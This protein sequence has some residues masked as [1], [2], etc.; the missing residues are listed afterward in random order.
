MPQPPPTAFP[1]LAPVPVSTPPSDLQVVVLTHELTRGGRAKSSVDLSCALA[2]RGYRVTCLAHPR[3]GVPPH[4]AA[5]LSEAGVELRL[6]RP[7][8]VTSPLTLLRILAALSRLS[9]DVLV[10]HSGPLVAL[11]A[12]LRRHYGNPH[13]ILAKR[14]FWTP[15]GLWRP[16]LRRAAGHVDAVACVS[17]AVARFWRLAEP[18]WDPSSIFVIHNGVAVPAESSAS[19]DALRQELGLPATA[20]VVG[21]VARMEWEK[22]HQHLIESLPRVLER[23]P[24]AYLVFAGEGAYLRQLRRLAADMGLSERVLFLGWREDV[25]TVMRGMDVFVHATLLETTPH[26]S[27]RPP[28]R[29]V[30]LSPDLAGEPFGR[31]VIEAGSVGVSVV[32][33]D[34]GGHR[35]SIVHGETGLLV[36]VADPEAL[37]E[38]VLHLLIHPDDARRMGEAARQRVLRHFSL[39]ALGRSYHYLIQRLIASA[40]S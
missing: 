32:A 34:A 16:L 17:G 12:P 7:G 18:D 8:R 13:L 20:Q 38:A 39:S 9:P 19:R 15:V 11:L 5:Q 33:T 30:P 36:P 27:H 35:E 25:P 10:A 6:L 1:E 22:G 28:R 23:V 2:D 21:T 40:E 31:A 37:A 14:G 24:D 26:H 3:F 29:T 4:S